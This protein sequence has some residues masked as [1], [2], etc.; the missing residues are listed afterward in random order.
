MYYLLKSRPAGPEDPESAMLTYKPDRLPNGFLRQWILGQPF[1][2]PPPIPV[3][4]TIEPGEGGRVDDYYD[5][6][7]YLMTK[8]LADFFSAVGVDNLDTYPC[9]ILDVETQNV[10]TTHVAFNVVGR[11][12]AANLQKSRFTD[13]DGLKMFDSMSIDEA[14]A[15]GL[16]LFR[17]HEAPSRILVHQSIKMRAEAKGIQSLMFLD[18]EQLSA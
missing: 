15:R 9:E 18:P 17:L 4:V 13:I 12:A 16:L 14:R 7:I 8:Q 1:D 6:K 11:V 3:K 5:S 10:M 2:P